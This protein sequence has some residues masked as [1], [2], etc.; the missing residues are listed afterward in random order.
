MQRCLLAAFSRAVK[1]KAVLM[2]YL[3][4]NLELL[5]EKHSR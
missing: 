3:K 5:R 4:Q 1:A 2:S